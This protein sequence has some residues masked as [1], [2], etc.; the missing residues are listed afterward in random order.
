[1]A[2]KEKKGRGAGRGKSLQQLAQTG[3]GGHVYREFGDRDASDVIDIP[4]V[5]WRGSG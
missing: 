4:S 3:D 5:T 2:K 1:M